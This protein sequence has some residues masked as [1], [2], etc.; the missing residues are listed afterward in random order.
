MEAV[1][2]RK[3]IHIILLMLWLGY[4][5]MAIAQT[6]K[7]QLEVSET[8]FATAT[9]L[10][11]C[12]YDTG[13][14]QSL[15]LRE[16]VRGEV[17]AAIKSLPQAAQ[18][19]EALCQFWREHQPP[20]KPEDAEQ[21]ISLTLE[22]GAPP[23]FSTVV[24][25]SDVPPDA[26]HV[27]GVISLLEKF[28]QAVG[29]HSMWLK[30]Q[31]EYQELVEQYHDPVAKLI[32]QTDLYLRLPFSSYPGQRFVVY[33]EPM[34]APEH[35][36]SRNYG[37]NYFVVVSPGRDGL[38][39]LAEI[40]H[41]YLHYVFDPLALKH[42]LSM[43]KIE[44]LLLD[45]RG[46]PMAP[47]YKNDVTLLV[48]ECLIRAIEARLAIPASNE[49]GRQAYVQRSVAEGFVLTRYFYDSLGPFEK[50]STGMLDAYGDLLY[51]IDVEREHKR[52]RSTTFAAE[53]T[54]E[55]ISSSKA[56]SAP[57]L[58]DSAEQKLALGDT[59][60]AQK[61]AEEVAHHNSGGDEPGHAAFI[62]ARVATL[63]GNMDEAQID[64]QQATQSV[65]DPHML[66]WSHIYLGRIYDIQ[67]KREAALAEY[68]AALT[69]GDPAPETRAA[70][71]RGLAA[72]YAPR[73]AP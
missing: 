58:L 29:V 13:L 10:N 59:A 34:L 23:M 44:P 47:A 1:L 8:F 43:K 69:A 3:S 40:R 64:F 35:V 27:L 9:A 60:S 51:N 19:H 53:A 62:L 41:T 71:E 57:S 6:T 37:T 15:A 55:V 25:E 17:Q 22:L 38:M 65:R 7:A 48:N 45:L 24:P 56:Y 33:L 32:T 68:Q 52:A 63:A 36:D 4:T 12:G 20:S 72:P 14:Q 42:A 67:L 2:R 31:K 26:G 49:A 11:S 39:R 70:A 28:Y 30:R 5:G 54:P 18:A 61:L 50:E 21:Y 73:K 66:A 46:A 16:A